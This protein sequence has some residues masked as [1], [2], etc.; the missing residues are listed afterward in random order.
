VARDDEFRKV[1]EEIGALARSLGRDLRE[2]VDQA[3]RG[4]YP[5]GR[6]VRDGLRDVTDEARRG[7]RTGWSGPSGRRHGHHHRGWGPG[8]YGGWGPPSWGPPP[9]PGAPAGVAGPPGSKFANP[10]AGPAGAAGPTWSTSPPWTGPSGA[11]A[12]GPADAAAWVRPHGNRSPRRR[13]QLPPVRHRW[14]ATTV[15]GMLVVLFGVAWLI[16]ATNVLHVSIE[17]V[18]AVGLMLLGASLV[19]TGRTDWSLSRRSWPVWLGVGLILV[20]VAT[21]SAFGLGSSLNSISF[22]NMSRPVVL[23]SSAPGVVHGGFGNLTVTLSSNPAENETLKVVTLAGQTTVDLP[24]NRQYNVAY[25]ARVVGGQICVDGE[26]PSN[27]LN[28]HSH[29][30]IHSSPKPLNPPTLTLDVKQMF[31]QI[32][33]GDGGC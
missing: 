3:V 30:T 12:C 9:D 25:D 14:D 20:L 15:A 26:R 29:G 21:S 18:A 28:V 16:G 5:P 32:V 24:R 1:A 27:G 23:G 13:D 11:P 31:G 19:V 17:G 33:I 8:Y 7:L 22:G 10:P 6:S 4:G 2:A